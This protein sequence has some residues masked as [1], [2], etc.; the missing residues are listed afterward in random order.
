MDWQDK[1]ADIRQMIAKRKISLLPIMV[2][3]TVA[4]WPAL[5]AMS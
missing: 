3:W 5:P 2:V 4:S 1:L